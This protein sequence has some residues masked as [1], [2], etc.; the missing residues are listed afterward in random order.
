MPKGKYTNLSIRRE[1]REELDKIREELK[2]NDLNDLLILLVKTYREHT[3][4]VS[5]LD[6]ITN[7]ISR[8][9]TNAISKT[10]SCVSDTHTNTVSREHTNTVSKSEEPKPR[11]FCKSKS[12]IRDVS[13]YVKKLKDA[14]VLIDWWDEGSKYCFEVRE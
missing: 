12:E 3:N 1:V 2:I 4:I 13:R 8:E 5:K 10:I 6:E 9:I 14:G 11:V 7:T